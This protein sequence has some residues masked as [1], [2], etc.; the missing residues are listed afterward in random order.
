MYA[1]VIKGSKMHKALK[2][3][4]YRSLPALYSSEDAAFKIIKASKKPERLAIVKIIK[5]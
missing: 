4:N 1:V 5:D 2:S 3:E